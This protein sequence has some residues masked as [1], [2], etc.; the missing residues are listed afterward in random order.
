MHARARR[1][2]DAPVIELGPKWLLGLGAL[3]AP[4]PTAMREARGCL[5]VQGCSSGVA[6]IG[7]TVSIAGATARTDQR[8][9]F[10]VRTRLG[11]AP[12]TV[13]VSGGKMAG[14]DLQL[15]N[16]FPESVVFDGPPITLAGMYI[17]GGCHD[18][19]PGGFP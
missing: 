17:G 7:A 15:D 13:A 9:C 8:G 5:V 6:A 11:L 19:R 16:P 10:S 3:A 4:E 12:V 2:T 14:M 18:A 1:L